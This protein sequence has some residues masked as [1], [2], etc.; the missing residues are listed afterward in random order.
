[1]T[2]F[3]VYTSIH[4]QD[5]GRQRP[6]TRRFAARCHRGKS[7]MSSNG[8]RL[9][10]ANDN[11]LSR[12]QMVYIADALLRAE[13][14]PR[15]VVARIRYRGKK[16]AWNWLSKR[17]RTG[18]AALWLLARDRLPLEAANDN[19]PSD[20][21]SVDRRKDGKIRGRNPDPRNLEAYLALPSV[22]PRL[23]DAETNPVQ[24]RGWHSDV[25]AIKPQRQPGE[26][27]MH[28]FGRFTRCL[29]AIAEG[30]VFLGAQSGLGQPKIGKKRGDLR[31]ADQPTIA[32]PPEDVDVVIEV[33]LSG[34][35]VADVGKALGAK[36]GYADRRGGAALLAAGTWAKKAVANDRIRLCA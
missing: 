26:Y 6:A 23:G 4:H 3:Y 21:M 22:Q 2:N 8:T 5:E 32:T 1:M 29:P 28:P 33:I 35:N 24:W 36:G 27:P 14:A 30:A 11:A 15:E 19:Q 20:G 12:Q 25:I 13:P 34:G 7:C 18:A 16:P 9:I 31:R 17:D 10:A